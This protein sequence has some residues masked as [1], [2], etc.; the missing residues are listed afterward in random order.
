M[1][2]RLGPRA[3]TAAGAGVRG[4][5]LTAQLHKAHT[6]QDTHWLLLACVC[7]WVHTRLS[8]LMTTMLALMYQ[9][10]S[11]I[12]THAYAIPHRSHAVSFISK[13]NTDW[14]LSLPPAGCGQTNTHTPPPGP[15]HT[16]GVRFAATSRGARGTQ[17]CGNTPAAAAPVIIS[18]HTTRQPTST[19]AA[20]RRGG[21]RRSTQPPAAPTAAAAT[22]TTQDLSRVTQHTSRACNGGKQA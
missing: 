10:Y 2:G 22:D 9:L 12:N 7:A 16:P 11:C 1:K 21:S 3:P 5:G 18:Q 6:A 15:T 20:A 14:H 8:R 17:P 13:V 19:S 4:T